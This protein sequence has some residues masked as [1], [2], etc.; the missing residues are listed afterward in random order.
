MDRK[1]FTNICYQPHYGSLPNYIILHLL[2]ENV[3]EMKQNEPWKDWQQRA[4]NDQLQ[5]PLK[6]FNF[7]VGGGASI[8]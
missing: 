3:S 4:H 6:L 8:L 1:N 7:K 5:T 2:I